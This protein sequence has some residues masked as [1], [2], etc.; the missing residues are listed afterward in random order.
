MC[1]F[2]Y[3]RWLLC[4]RNCFVIFRR[5][6]SYFYSSFKVTCK[7]TAPGLISQP[8]EWTDL[9]P[10]TLWNLNSAF[11]LSLF[12][13]GAILLFLHSRVLK[14]GVWMLRPAAPNQPVKFAALPLPLR[15][16]PKPVRKFHHRLF[17]SRFAPAFC[18]LS[19]HCFQRRLPTW[20]RWNET[21]S[22]LS[23]WIKTVLL[24][25]INYPG[26]WFTSVWTPQRREMSFM[27]PSMRKCPPRLLQEL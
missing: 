21:T 17:P 27:E 20:Q 12:P 6:C 10:F 8:L 3:L 19:P 26:D 24:G 7:T 23:D 22:T 9:T 15:P 4:A 5:W 1:V 14:V 13:P 25:R 11:L 16:P 18:L 2:W